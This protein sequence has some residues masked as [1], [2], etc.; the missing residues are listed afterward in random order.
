[1]IGVLDIFYVGPGNF[2]QCSQ[3]A[4]IRNSVECKVPVKAQQTGHIAVIF[5]KFQPQ[6]QESAA[7]QQKRGHSKS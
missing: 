1:M 7:P 6:H 3:A 5:Y 2:E 4:K